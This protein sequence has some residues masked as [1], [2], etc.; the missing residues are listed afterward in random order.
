MQAEQERAPRRP[1]AAL[2]EVTHGE[3]GQRAELPT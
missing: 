3:R 1:E 2:M